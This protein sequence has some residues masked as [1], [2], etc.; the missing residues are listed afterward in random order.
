MMRTA[1]VVLAGLVLL[2]RP[3]LTGESFRRIVYERTVPL[4]AEAPAVCLSGELL[5]S[6][7]GPALRVV[8]T[9]TGRE[10]F[11][12][13]PVPGGGERPADSVHILGIA[14]GRLYARARRSDIPPDDPT[15][16][17]G[18]I[19]FG[20]Q[21]GKIEVVVL[22]I[23]AGRV[24][25][26]LDL[27]MSALVADRLLGT[28]LVY[29]QKRR[30]IVMPLAGGRE[31]TFEL[32]GEA[33]MR[34]KVFGDRVL[35]PC[36]GSAHVYRDGAAGARRI[37]YQGT[38]LAPIPTGRDVTLGLSGDLIVVGTST[39]VF[40]CDMEG[41]LRW[42]IPAAGS[43]FTGPAG[44]IFVNYIATYRLAPEDG[45]VIWCRYEPCR[46]LYD[47]PAA[48]ISGDRLALFSES[49]LTVLDSR[50]GAMVM[51]MPLKMDSR[52]KSSSSRHTYF[53]GAMSGKL[54]ALGYG[55]W[56]KAVDVTATS[57]V[58]END[59]AADPANA[60]AKLDSLGALTVSSTHKLRGIARDLA[61]T[62]EAA[63]KVLPVLREMVSGGGR[64]LRADPFLDFAWIDDPVIA[65]GLIRAVG[66]PDGQRQR[67]YKVAAALASLP[68]RSRSRSA[69]EKI[70]KDS[71]TYG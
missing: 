56:V 60:L 24:T 36:E 15:R 64:R 38:G 68:D 59:R 39:Q 45:R 55:E 26:L 66:S 28:N 20:R 21:G 18:T 17:M 48:V 51:N 43:V 71:T 57:E 11:S 47:E 22:D 19:R 63:P 10:L 69:L 12:G 4:G 27:P 50:T 46:V 37:R 5:A 3:G 62:P 33:R 25:G 7:T 70:T 61:D 6:S 52:R 34:P 9:R 31:R 65:Q 49:M 40:A 58:H 44:E 1:A 67:S 8:D 32:A 29:A 16:R 2:A 13:P 23:E 42:K 35:C 54:L 30:L 53:R 41:K 14:G